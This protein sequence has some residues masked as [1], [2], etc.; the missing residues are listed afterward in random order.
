[1]NKKQ[2]NTADTANKTDTANEITGERMNRYIASC[3]LCSRRE[4]D[5]W[6]TAGRVSMNGEAIQ[7]P[8]VRVGHLDSVKVDGKLISKNNDKTYILYN[9]PKGLLCSRKDARKRP[10]IYDKLDVAP[11]VQSIGRLD[12]DSEGLL[13]LT[14]DGA[15]AQELMH[16]RNNIARQYRARIVGQ[17]DFETLAKLRA[18]GIDMGDGD[19]SDAWELVVSSESKGHSWITLTI[20]RGRWREVRRTLKAVGHEVRRLMRVRFGNLGLDI[21]LRPGQ[22]R[23]LKA[24]EIQSLQR[25]IKTPIKKINQ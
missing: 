2:M 6:I 15:L 14:D 5:R 10:L 18:G 1:M 16:P 24:K 17:P 9:K 25:L 8:G 20:H 4:A 23:S 21:E 11:N 19:K 3:G 12:M 7:E 13:L 22:W